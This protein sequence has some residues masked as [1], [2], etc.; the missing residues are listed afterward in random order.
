MTTPV[1]RVVSQFVPFGIPEEHRLEERRNTLMKESAPKLTTL[2]VAQTYISSKA[3][4]RLTGSV[5]GAGGTV[6]S[7]GEEFA[8]RYEALLESAPEII[9]YQ[10][11][12]SEK[13]FAIGVV[14]ELKVKRFSADFKADIYSVAAAASLSGAQVQFERTIMPAAIP[15]MK[16]VPDRGTLTSDIYEGLLDGI[17]DVFS[18]LATTENLE[19]VAHYRPAAFVFTREGEFY[20]AVAV[21]FAASQLAQYVK[22]E[23]ALKEARARRFDDAVVRATYEFFWPGVKDDEKPP[24]DARNSAADLL[25]WERR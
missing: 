18:S 8:L 20:E 25:G 23:D 16:N 10:N 7:N 12:I 6:G 3:L 19:P 5:G 24:R 2:R 22:L 13:V 4:A 1:R 21:C 9:K 17:S 11:V 15:V 14:L